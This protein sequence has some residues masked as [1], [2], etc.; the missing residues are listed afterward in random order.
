LLDHLNAPTQQVVHRFAFTPCHYHGFT[1]AE[2][3]QLAACHQ[4]A[5]LG[6]FQVGEQSVAGQGLATGLDVGWLSQIGGKG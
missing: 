6:R 5:D 1:W 4:L 2:A 3:E